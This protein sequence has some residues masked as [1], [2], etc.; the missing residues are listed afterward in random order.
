MAHPELTR[1][2]GGHSG[3]YGLM[4]QIAALRWISANIARFGGDPAQVTIIGQSA[5]ASSVASLI[6][7]PQ[8]KGLFRS[9]AM[10]S[11]C[12]FRSALPTLTDAEAIGLAVQKRL[13]VPSL[14]AMRNI[15]ADRILATQS[16]SQVGA[17]VEGVRIGGPIIDGYVQPAQKPEMLAA[18]TLNRIPIIADYTQDDI[19]IGMSPFGKVQTLADYRATANQLFGKDAEAFLRLFPATSDTEARTAALDAARASGFALSARQC[20]Q[21]QAQIGQAAHIALFAHKHPY[22]PGVTFADQNP[23]TIG[24]YHTADVPYWLG[25]LDAYNSLRVTRAWTAADRALSDTMMDALIGFARNGDP[26]K[27]WP[28]WTAGNEALLTFGATPTLGRFDTNRMNWLD[29]HPVA[30]QPLAARPGLPRD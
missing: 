17:H 9:A 28:R 27:F 30:R 16:E 22:A 12:N 14:A 25:T 21:D 24:V 10:S 11:G 3:N 23:A 26:G 2:Q 13:A 15:P 8:A 20:A 5:G 1:E 6:F 4:D 29:A 18:G 7:A 19:D